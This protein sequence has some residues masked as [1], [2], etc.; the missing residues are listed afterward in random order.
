MDTIFVKGSSRNSR[1][2]VGETMDKL[3]EYMPGNHVFIITDRNVYDIYETSFPRFPV[4]TLKPGE[5]T[6]TP[7]SAIDICRWLMDNGGGR[8]AFILGI[9]GGMVCDMAGFV[10]SV[11]MRGVAFGFVATSLLAQVDASLGGKNGVNLDGYKNIIGTFNQPQFV[12][13]D[14]TMLHSL[15]ADEL[16]N[17]LA[18]AVKHTLIADKQMFQHILNHAGEILALDEALINKLVRHSIEVKSAIVGRDETEAGERRKLNLGHTWGHAVEKTDGIAH[19]QAV[20]IGLSFAAK[21]SEKKQMLS[22][23]DRI[24]INELLHSFNLPTETDT[25]PRQIFRALVRDKKKE[26]DHIH[27]VLMNGIGQVTVEPLSLSELDD[28]IQTI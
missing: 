27:F 14:T 6:K 23:G 28:F 1:I 13:C 24:T 18:E 25:D 2:L 4:Y 22:T 16:K 8:D 5:A 21:L 26:G 11:F 19:G 7:D 12:L 20:S 3:P 17:G 15:P 10:A 9:G